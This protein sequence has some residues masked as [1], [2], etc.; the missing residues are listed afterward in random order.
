MVLSGHKGYNYLQMMWLLGRFRAISGRGGWKDRLLK[1]RIARAALAAASA[2]IIS[3]GVDAAPAKM[4][5]ADN[6][7]LERIKANMHLLGGRFRDME[8]MA[9][10]VFTPPRGSGDA[11]QNR[12]ITLTAHLHVKMPDKV[13]FQVLRSSLPLFNRWIF[14]Q[15]GDTMAAYDPVADRRITT[16]FKRLTG[17]EPARVETS[18]AMLGLMFDP[19]RY[20]FQWMGRAV[21]Q[22]AP[23]YHVRLRHLKPQQTGPLTII[24]RTDLY[25]DTRRLIPV[26]SA[27]YD[28]RGNLATT[29]VFREAKQTPLGWAPTRITITDHEFE[30]LHKSG[31]LDRARKKLS[32][33][34][35]VKSPADGVAPM[36]FGHQGASAPN[37]FRNGTLDLWI[38]WKDGVFFPWKMLATTPHGAASLWTFSNTK[39]NSGVKD[40][41]FQL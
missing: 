11:K 37:A 3:S 13:K 8:T 36:V 22:G 2:L 15:K 14:L 40:S 26:Y 41:V 29:T 27:S 33:G 4:T 32:K 9:D 28:V 20:S 31:K 10:L 35:G 34:A 19:S 23:V 7:T 1:T 18:M 6:K 38:G 21:R 12:Q 30:R 39:V 5:A 17:H 24:A 25:V 16:D